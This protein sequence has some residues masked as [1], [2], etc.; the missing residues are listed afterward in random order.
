MAKKP[1]RIQVALNKANKVFDRILDVYAWADFV[2]ITGTMGG[3]VIKR[4]YYDN[5]TE[6]DR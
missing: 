3:D 6:C 5:G 1:N 4:R 2:D